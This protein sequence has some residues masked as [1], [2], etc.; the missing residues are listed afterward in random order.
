MS[1][2]RPVYRGSVKEVR[3]LGDGLLEFRF[4]D[5]YSVFDW[6]AMPDEIPGKGEALAALAAFF[7][8]KLGDPASWKAFSATPEA[9]SLRRGA[10]KCP[11]PPGGSSIPLLFN[12]L[13]ETL[14]SEGLRNHFRGS[15]HADAR[16]RFREIC[17]EGVSIP[18]P[19]EASVLGRMLPDY[20]GIEE[21]P[22]PR[23]I[24]IEFVFR[25]SAPKGSSLRARWEKG[26][27]E[28]PPLGF[29]GI[30]EE[31]DFP[32][33]ECFTKLERTDRL[34]PLTEAFAISG[35][36]AEA[37]QET[38]LRTAWVA[39]FLRKRFADAGLA[40]A[41][42]KLEWAIGADGKPILVDAIGPDELR[43]LRGPL[44]FSK[45]FLRRHYR[46]TEWYAAVEAAKLRAKE[47]GSTDWKKG[48]APPPPLPEK[49]L[50]LASDVYGT[51]AKIVAGSR[52]FPE[53]PSIVLLAERLAEANR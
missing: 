52:G 50:A 34:L 44:D 12:E 15:P 32:V 3:E 9:H 45:E 36:T 30:E 20:S 14:Q 17:V 40:L 51:L 26:F 19:R 18:R 39:G 41:D 43:L 31:W 6:G 4:T 49:L 35:V 25:F 1:E 53:A 24:P 37:F 33:L 47:A 46:G 16:G 21:Y 10:S 5:Q 2:S 22:A 38:L 11:R 28:S 8:E 13:G 27:L 23:L 29:T 7:F 42:G 48:V